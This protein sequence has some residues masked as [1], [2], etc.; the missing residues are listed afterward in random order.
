MDTLQTILKLMTKD[1][2]M[3]CI[4]IKDAYHDILVDVKFEKFLKFEFEGCL[5]CFTCFPNGFGPCPR[6]FTKTLKPPLADLRDKG[7]ISSAY[8]E[9]IY[10]QGSTYDE[11]VINVIDTT[12]SLDSLGFTVHLIK[13]QFLPK[14][15]IT[16]LGFIL[17][18]R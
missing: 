5:Y 9:D 14:Q 2:F 18:S 4:D 12:I 10:L 7:H 11:C 6:K 1:W 13:T 17:N 16:C 3:A 8:I 15:I